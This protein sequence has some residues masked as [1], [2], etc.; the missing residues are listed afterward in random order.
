MS[1]NSFE[2]KTY[3][4]EIK[5]CTFNG[6]VRVIEGWTRDYFLLLQILQIKLA[7]NTTKKPISSIAES[8]K[9]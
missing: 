5:R 1:K 7:L 4:K 8:P 6:I 3:K 2:K 9:N